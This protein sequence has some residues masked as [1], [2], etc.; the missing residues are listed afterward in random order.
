MDWDHNFISTLLS[1]S[2]CVWLCEYVSAYAFLFIC[3][4]LCKPSPILSIKKKK[5]LKTILMQVRW[6]FEK[7]NDQEADKSQY[8]SRSNWNSQESETTHILRT[9]LKYSRWRRLLCLTARFKLISKTT[10]L[11]GKCQSH[12]P[13]GMIFDSPYQ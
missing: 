12:W 1:L 13:K 7:G 5:G 6:W 9:K 8:W 4:F 10:Y 2:L 3:F 11:G